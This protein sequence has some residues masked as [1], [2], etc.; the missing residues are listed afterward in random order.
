MFRP[1]LRL[2]LRSAAIAIAAAWI[3][4]Q[5]LGSVGVAAT[6]TPQ[7]I[8][9]FLADPGAILTQQQYQKGGAAS[10]R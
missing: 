6:L 2:A 3:T 9:Q 8:T 5:P 7:Q 1:Y 4:L 10:C